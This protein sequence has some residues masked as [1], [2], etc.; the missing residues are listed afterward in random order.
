MTSTRQEISSRAHVAVVSICLF[1]TSLFL[2]AYSSRYPQVARVGNAL[3]LEIVA[4]ISSIVETTRVGVVT[5]WRRY[6]YLIHTSQ[7]N[8][9]LS[10]RVAE[11]EGKL[12]AIGESQRENERL[13]EIL[14]FSTQTQLSGVAARVVGADASGW[15]GGLVIDRGSRDGIKPGMA[16]VHA[17]GVVGQVASAGSSSA[18]VLVVFDHSSGVDAIVESSRARGVLE[19]VGDSLCEL[20]FV[21]KDVAVKSGDSVVTSGLDQVYPKGLRLGTVTDVATNSG[22]LFQAIEVKP[23]VDFSRLEEVLVLT[24]SGASAESSRPLEARKR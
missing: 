19:G 13:R 5:M 18:R 23:A 3:V 10:S 24:P 8:E 7:E 6:V 17:G 2:T 22:A 1:V 11:L 16:V 20:K 15:I 12:A 14:N 21:T 9:K 4:P